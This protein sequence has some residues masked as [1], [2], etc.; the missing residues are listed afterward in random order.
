MA[1]GLPDRLERGACGCGALEER[2]L[3]QRQ[4]L[5]NPWRWKC[6]YVI[7]LAL[8]THA[9]SAQQPVSPGST[10]AASPPSQPPPR[11]IA[12][13][14]FERG[15]ELLG[16]GKAE[17]ALIEFERA[18]SVLPAYQVLYYVGDANFRLERWAKA[19]EALERYLDLGAS[20]LSP[21]QIDEVR[22]NLE[23][24]TQRTASLSLSSNVA[25]AEVHVNGARLEPTKFSGLILDGG[26][27]QIRVVKP[28]FHPLEQ[29][30]HATEGQTLHLVVQLMPRGEAPAEALVIPA[31]VASAALPPLP[32]EE[33]ERMPSWVPWSITGA[34]AAAWATTAALAIK[35]RHDRNIIERPG[36]SS[37]R[38]DDARRTHLTLAVVSDVLLASTLASAGVSAYLTWWDEPGRQTTRDPKQRQGG[39]GFSAGISWDF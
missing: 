8:L 14:A 20:Q 26:E 31:P 24:L 7:G 37:E 27:H 11:E 18:Y 6:R 19:R 34:L 33:E 32:Y 5:T 29:T 23:I 30:I 36:V 10:G 16:N 13:T 3:V 25:G 17:E 35:A 22:T 4:A 39:V 12:A 28:G 2:S 21:A 9:A 38:I 15:K 1:S